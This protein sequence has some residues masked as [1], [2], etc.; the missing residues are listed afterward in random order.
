M[1]L[2]RAIGYDRPWMEGELWLGMLDLIEGNFDAALAHLEPTLDVEDWRWDPF[3]RAVGRSLLG[4][5]HTAQG[6]YRDAR[7][8]LELGLA[9]AAEHKDAFGEAQVRRGLAW[10]AYV[11]GDL[12]GA[13]DELARAL[14][15]L[16]AMDRR[17][18]A[19]CLA[20]EAHVELAGGRF[21]AAKAG[22][23]EALALGRAA[24]SVR[25]IAP[26]L[27]VEAMLAR[28]AGESDA[29]ED[30]F[31]EMLTVSLR[32]G[33]RPGV[34]EALYGLAGAVADGERFEEA[35][36]LHAAAQTL[37]DRLGYTRLPIRQIAHDDDIQ[38]VA[39]ALGPAGFEAAWNEGAALST[40]D[41][42]AYARRRRGER[43]RPAHGWNSLT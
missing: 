34:C 4:E 1:R 38:Q 3:F 35:A 30:L 14:G 16:R 33:H 31:H 2:A 42:A 12:G 13:A 40:Q 32:A 23:G 28:R 22:A 9:W 11:E 6:R 10:L 41:A 17:E 15:P 7:E 21:D 43:K 24:D 26:A 37:R 25:A 5:V 18:A 39:D 8:Q 19:R 27:E 29:A 20:L 36:R